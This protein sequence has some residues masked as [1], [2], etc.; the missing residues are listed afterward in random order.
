MV[1]VPLAPGAMAGSVQLRVAPGVQ[2]PAPSVRTNRAP[3]GMTSVR[4]T[5]AA[6]LGP[7]L[8]TVT[9]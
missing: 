9:T 2:V 1:S 6:A 7:W 3:E 5:P 8:T 4:V